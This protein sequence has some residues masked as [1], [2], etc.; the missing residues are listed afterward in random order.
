MLRSRYR[1]KYYLF[2][3][4]LLF[5]HTKFAKFARSYGSEKTIF[6]SDKN[7]EIP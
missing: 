1:N 3:H 2:L 7:Y 4:I 6:K 5:S